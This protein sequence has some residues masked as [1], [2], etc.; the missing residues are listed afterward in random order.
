[1]R[2]NNRFFLVLLVLACNA[3]LMAEPNAKMRGGDEIVEIGFADISLADF[4]KTVSKITGKNI[5]I[6]N[7]LQGKVDFVS[8]R[9]LRKSELYDL[10]I[11]T[12]E[13][14]GFTIVDSGKGYLKV[15]PSADAV[16]NNLPVNDVGQIPQMR[17]KVIKL[18]NLKATDIQNNVRH[19]LSK[20]GTIQASNDANSLLVSD[21]PANVATIS[22]IVSQME[23]DGDKK[24]TI[25]SVI[26]LKNGDSE[27]ISKVLN[28]MLS[29]KTTPK[30]ASKPLI[31]YDAHTN[32]VIIVS[33]AE[34]FAELKSVIASLDIERQQVYVKARIIELS[35]SKTR[36]VGVKYGIEGA[37][38]NSSGLYSF[39]AQMGG[40]TI[41]LSS[42]ILNT[43]S[44]P[45]LKEGLAIGAAISLLSEE[46]AANLLSEPS[47]LCINNQ[48]SSIY[49]GK[50]EPVITQST[51][52]T[53][54][55]DL[56]RNSYT[57]Q[58]IGLM[59]KV[60]P[61]LSSD[62]KVALSVE[63]KL[64]DTLPQSQ[65]GLPLTTKREIK[66]TAIVS[67][68]EAVIIGGLIKDDD[69]SSISKVPF[70]GDIPFLGALFRYKEGAKDKINLV[71]ILTPYIVDKSMDLAN[72]RARLNELD[73]L[74]N[75]YARKMKN[76][77]IVEK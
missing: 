21:F 10:L 54:T 70:L 5:L 34:E 64:E 29:K 58:D 9:P 37:S 7:D 61:R 52:S 57:R 71:I 15:I 67:N 49:V 43:I 74:Q 45:N 25:T 20:N 53:S 14:K 31:S 47:I 11:N 28:D 2:L 63:A 41:A 76:N 46:N 13:T 62:G 35:D 6:S 68:G 59:L 72:L 32:S 40:P 3:L 27:N 48:E 22:K 38:S 44:M 51:L 30:D 73:K 16:R 17:T 23:K 19:L 60:K 39:A 36:A 75:E 66:T 1:M 4:V 55:T 42:Q 12:L 69:K 24:V 56:T 65:L 8:Q 33:T 50:T 26:A 18:N 77:E